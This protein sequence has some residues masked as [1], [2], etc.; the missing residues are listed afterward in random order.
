MEELSLMKKKYIQL[1]DRIVLSHKVSHTYLFELDDYDNDLKYVYDFIKMILLDISYEEL[2][3]SSDPIISLIDKGDYP[4]IFVVSP[5]GNMIKKDQMIDLQLEFNN[6]SLIGNKRF[7]IIKNAEKLNSSSANTILKFLEEPEDNIYAFLLVDNRYHVLDTILSR[8]QIL[9]LSENGLD[10]EVDDHV[11]SLLNYILH[12]KEF[13]VQYNAFVN[14]FY[15]DKTLLKEGLLNVEKIIVL[16][17]NQNYKIGKSLDKSIVDIFQSCDKDILIRY[18]SII[19][20]EIPKLDFNINYKL[21]LDS[22]FSR[23][24]LGGELND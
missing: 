17:L 5:D 7:Y 12:P 15:V 11:L 13:F 20:E 22:L 19:E 8:C 9:T 24:V 4:D 14:D 10:F 3:K 16:Y 18:L 6:T 21:W 2:D 23:L 1:I